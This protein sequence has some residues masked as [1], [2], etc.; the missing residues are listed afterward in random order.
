MAYNSTIITKKKIC[1]SCGKKDF[2]FSE[3][4][5][6][7]CSTIYST[8]KRI[9]KHEEDEEDLS[10]KYLIE[11]LYIVFSQYIR[12]KYADKNGMVECYTSGTK[13]HYTKIQNGHYIPRSSLA[14]RWMEDNCR[15]QS[16]HDNCGLHGNIEIFAKNLEK[17][18]PGIT[19][20]LLEQSRQ[21]TK[22]T[23]E[24]LKSLIVEYRSKLELAKKKFN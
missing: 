4:K 11:D 7:E 3:K 5:C 13:H 6:K 21:I 17:D 10:L 22:P 23:R 14:T 12:I 24:E 1:I 2:W 9:A 19:N 15:P 20:Y 18:K 8:Q 16:E